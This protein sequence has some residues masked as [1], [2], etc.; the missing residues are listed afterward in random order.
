[1]SDP[2]RGTMNRARLEWILSGLR[3]YRLSPSED[4]FVKSIEQTFNDKNMLTDKEE[5]KLEGFH[6]EKSRL[7]A[8]RDLYSP[9]TPATSGEK[10][11]RRTRPKIIR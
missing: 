2:S 6:R 1:M 4:R 7:V 8:D 11:F 5:E 10:K 3:R 9:K